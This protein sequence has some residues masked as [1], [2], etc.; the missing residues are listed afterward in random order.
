[1]ASLWAQRFV[2]ETANIPLEE[3]DG[4]FK[5]QVGREELLLKEQVS[6]YS[7]FIYIERRKSDFSDFVWYKIIKEVGLDAVIQELTSQEQD[8]RER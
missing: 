5:A 8:E 6:L 4:L 7:T 1:M 3:V 2:P